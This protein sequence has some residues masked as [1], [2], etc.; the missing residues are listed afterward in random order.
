MPSPP[1][2]AFNIDSLVKIKLLPLNQ[3]VLRISELL[4]NQNIST[5]RLAEAVGFDPVLATR[6][7][8]MANSSLYAR[9]SPT[10]SIQQAIEAVGI[11]ALYDIVM[12]GA[13]ADGFAKEI[14]TTE[15]G[16]LIWEHSI[17]VGLLSRE[18][19]DTLNM[20]G[21][22]EAFL[23]GLLHDIG[24]ILLL[25][26]ERN[27]F[28][29]LLKNKSEAQILQDE[30]AVFGLTHAEVGAYVTHKWQLPDV[31]C[32]VIMHHH[33]PHLATVST[34]ITHIVNVADRFADVKGYGICPDT[35]DD[36]FQSESVAFLHLTPEQIQ[37]AWENIE[38]SF[39]EV[40]ATFG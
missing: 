29:K 8:K 24:R 36:V 5:R 13:F 35:E 12:M 17:A 34:V 7:L 18:L 21:T 11:K 33:E 2:P 31:V 10:V 4:R 37:T 27:I 28:E 16:R 38:S 30:E 6:L 20:R 15:A 19:S 40:V 25:K 9:K 26:A 32:G 1:R 23:C 22:E 39:A 14:D 3:T